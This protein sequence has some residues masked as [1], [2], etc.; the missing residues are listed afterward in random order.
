MNNNNKLVKLIRRL[1]RQTML[2]TVDFT[3]V[4]TFFSSWMLNKY[5]NRAKLHLT[6]CKEG[7]ARSNLRG[8]G[9]FKELDIQ[10]KG[11]LAAPKF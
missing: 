6:S 4:A 9:L 7:K 11:E 3:Y 2:F 8:T 5:I 10:A 1:Y